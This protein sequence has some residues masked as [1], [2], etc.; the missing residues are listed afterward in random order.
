M[1]KFRNILLCV[2]VVSLYTANAQESQK[3]QNTEPASFPNAIIIGN[4]NPETGGG[5]KKLPDKPKPMNQASLDSLNDNEKQKFLLLPPEKIPANFEV[6]TFPNGYLEGSFGSFLTPKAM[7]GLDF[8]IDKFDF[9]INGGFEGSDGHVTNADYTKIQAN[10]DI[11]YIAPEQFWLFGGSKTRTK[12]RFDNWNY[13]TYALDTADNINTTKIFI[14]TSTESNYNDFRFDSKLGFNIF[15]LNDNLND[16]SEFGINGGLF[17]HNPFG[18]DKFGLNAEVDFRTTNSNGNS[19]I[20]ANAVFPIAKG[21]FSF[22]IAPGVQLATNTISESKLALYADV[23]ISAI[24]NQDFTFYA[25]AN[26]GLS[27]NSFVDLFGINP[28]VATSPT[29]DYKHTIAMGKILF[30]YHPYTFISATFGASYSINKNDIGFTND[31]VFRFTPNY[32]GSNRL[33]AFAQLFWDINEL[34]RVTADLNFNIT[35]QDSTDKQLTYV[36]AVE[37]AANYHHYFTKEFGTII[38]AKFIGNRYAD[39]ANTIELDGYF[40][41]T[42]RAEYY[43]SE[44]LGAFVNLENII[45]QDIYIWNGYKQRGLFAQL[46][47]LYTF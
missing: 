2:L 44:N 47:V 20:K 42:F 33:K 36:P 7:A 3:P 19:M 28:Y 26:T 10:A 5:T 45:N 4:Y 35:T 21:D 15:S 16:G 32:V 39:F 18:S 29:I 38:G 8:N 37:F 9:F 40:D 17:L 41:I 27:N 1:N 46:G 25:I 11:D 31:S 24:M 30:N 34:Q 23:I 22:S 6:P 13:N 14:G 43:F 12:F